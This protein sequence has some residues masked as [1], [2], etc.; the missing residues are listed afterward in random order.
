MD[1]ASQSE[2]RSRFNIKITKH[3]IIHYEINQREDV[4]VTNGHIHTNHKN[5]TNIK[6]KIKQRILN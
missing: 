4:N 2:I 3:F 5:I 6:S 1:F